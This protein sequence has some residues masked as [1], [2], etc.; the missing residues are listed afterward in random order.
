MKLSEKFSLYGID[1]ERQRK[2][3]FPTRVVLTKGNVHGENHLTEFKPAQVAIYGYHDQCVLDNRNSDTHACV[4]V[5]FGRELHGTVTVSVWNTNGYANYI[6][7]L[8]ESVSE[9]LT[10]VGTN[11]AT[12]DHANRD[13]LTGSS[14][15]SSNETNESG[16]RFA[17]IELTSPGMFME[18]RSITATLVYRDI[19]YRGSFECSDPLINKIYDTAAY[20][21]HLNMQRYLWDGIKRDRLVWAGDMNTE[22]ATILAVFGENE[23]VPKSLDL[24]RDV[25]PIHESMN[26]LSSYN[27]WWL[28]CHAEWYKG[29]G[30]YDYLAAQRDYIKEMLARYTKYVDENGSEILP[31]GRFFDWPTANYPEA[32]HA[33]LQGLLRCALIGGGEIMKTLGE[34]ESAAE[35]FIAA[36]KLLMHKPNPTITTPDGVTTHWKQPAALLVMGGIM[37][38]KEAYDTCISK[39]GAEGFST[40]LGYYTLSAVAKAGEYNAALD[41]MRGYWGTMLGMGATTFWEDFDIN[42]AKGATPITE[43]VPEG[44]I[45][46]HGDFG[47]HCYV[48][49]RHS[50]CHGWASGPAPYLAANVLGIQPIA[51]GCKVVRFD[52]HL[53]GL[54]W[55]RGTYPT[56]YGNIEVEL[57]GDKAGVK[58]PDGVEVVE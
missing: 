11:N 2:V 45:D 1:D 12:N 21:V 49:L 3:L 16:F 22:L 19:E 24:V 10:P 18:I 58:A 37:D 9:A 29:T 20:T 36:D 30:N 7:R 31:N 15:W 40:F 28:L 17:C 34:S 44:G 26:G 56:P 52:P 51:P 57:K 32:M 38:A 8:G 4:L 25:T 6:V 13:F 48:K 42:W 43:A 5:D 14:P 41:M 55:A 23:V 27:L 39:G 50:L 46:I 54:D 35:C 47:S 53:S 33:G